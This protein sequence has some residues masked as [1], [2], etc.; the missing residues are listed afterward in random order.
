MVEVVEKPP[1]KLSRNLHGETSITAGGC[2]VLVS[3]LLSAGGPV[4]PTQL[5]SVEQTA[6]LP[7]T[8]G[9]SPPSQ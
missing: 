5:C 7:R 6:L 9:E 4:E 8:T 3:V 1:G 2:D